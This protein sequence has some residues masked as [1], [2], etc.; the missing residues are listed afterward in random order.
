MRYS[1]N[2]SNKQKNDH[3]KLDNELGKKKRGTVS[4]IMPFLSVLPLDDAV[5]VSC[6]GG[7]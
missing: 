4:I 3:K 6:F 7:A 5:D 1:I 2:K